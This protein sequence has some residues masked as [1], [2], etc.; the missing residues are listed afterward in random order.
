MAITVSSLPLII[1]HRGACGHAPENTL[2]S[3]RAAADL[4]VAWVE[5]DVKLSGDGELIILHDDTLDRTTTGRGPVTQ[6]TL[7]E[8]RR[9]DAGLFFDAEFRGEKV[10]TLDD[11]LAV[12]QDLNLGA[13]VEIKPC[14]GREAETGDRTARHLAAHWPGSLPAPLL[15]SFK[16]GAL[17]AAGAAV[18]A[19]ERA[20]LLE[21]MAE[22]WR[23][24]AEQVGVRAIHCG[25]GHLTESLAGEVQAAGYDLRC[26]TVNDG[27]RAKVLLDWGVQGIITDYPERMP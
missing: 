20:L 26:Y 16:P 23:H 1:G 9:L 2:A 10:P 25:H 14:P 11:T 6:H 5:F 8:I 21:V 19:L 17:A 7:A 24:L 4:G 27:A 18:P 3:F 15:C 12:L 13:V 22:D